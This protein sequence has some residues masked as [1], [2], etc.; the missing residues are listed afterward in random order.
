MVGI[1]RAP[2]TQEKLS[3][4]SSDSQ[5][6]LACACGTNDR[7]RRHRASDDRWLYPVSLPNG[8]YSVLFKTL[9]SNVCTNDCRYCPLRADQDC[10]RCT[11]TPEEVATCFMHYL[12]AGKV[13]GAFLSSGVVGTP[14][15]TM[16]RLNAIA[17][18]LR[19]KEGFR[20]YIH[21]KI[22]PGAS[23]AAIEKALS[24]SSAVSLNI[25]SAGEDHFRH[26]SSRKDYIRDIIRPLKLISSLT[27]RGA[28]YGRV[29]QSTQFVVGASDENDRE[30]VKYSWG[31][32]R[33]LGM[34]RVYFSAY[35]RGLGESDLPGERSPLS[36]RDLLT[37]E[38]RLYQVDWLMRKYAFRAEEIPFE[39]DGNLSLA[40]DPKELWAVRHPE[41][42]PL[43][44]N[45]ADREE[46]LRVPGLGPT[47]VGRI[48]ERRARGERIH[49][50]AELGAPHA[51]LRKAAEYLRF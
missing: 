3:V 13:F 18:L 27:A 12:R 2:D 34:D 37:R 17:E 48:L 29:K 43:D 38:H 50:A 36:N 8:G 41:R 1:L 11:L 45:R 15:A 42:F 47:T 30:I 32:Y 28:R 26:L 33:R 22:I 10:P 16:H 7:D 20:G 25:E 31:L 35:Q 49:R 51:R 39:G 6:D 9:V 19:R 4:L 44:V 40:L 5:Y 23:D 14:D 21:L 24:L 46:L